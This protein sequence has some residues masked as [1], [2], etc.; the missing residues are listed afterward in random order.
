[1]APNYPIFCTGE[2]V[3]AFED[4]DPKRDLGG[5]GTNIKGQVSEAQKVLLFN[6]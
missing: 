4:R 2:A 5:Y 1:L 6:M 3:Y